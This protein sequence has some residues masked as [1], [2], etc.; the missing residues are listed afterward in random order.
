MVQLTEDMIVARTRVTSMA[1]VKKLNCWGADLTDVSVVRKLQGLEVLSLSLNKLTSLSDFQHC[2]N[3]QE[4]YVKKNQI[5]SLSE[6]VWL[7][8]LSRL[9]HLWLAENP[10]AEGDD[11]YRQTV[12][13]NLPQLEKLDNISITSEERADAR[14]GIDLLETRGEE[15]DMDNIMNQEEGRRHSLEMHEA[16]SYRGCDEEVEHGHGQYEVEQQAPEQYQPPF[17]YERCRSSRSLSSSRSTYMSREDERSVFMPRNEERAVYTPIEEVRP[18]YKQRQ[19]ES[20]VFMRREEE[21]MSSYTG[22]RRD[23]LYSRTGLD[24]RESVCC[25][26]YGIRRSSSSWGQARMDFG[27]MQGRSRMDLVQDMART[28][29]GVT[30]RRNRNSNMLSAILC[31][32]KEIDIPSLEVVEMAVRCRMEEVED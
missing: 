27:V 8:G 21:E 18:A 20:P 28:Q 14:F 9:R 29:G 4:L 3:L 22:G 24:D 6:I 16:V 10:C 32:L 12:I 2:K 7:R 31:L 11:R 15:D 17:S 25:D 13:H 1:M 23:S 19:D 5:S 26:Q 30:R